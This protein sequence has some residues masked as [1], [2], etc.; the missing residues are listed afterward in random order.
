MMSAWSYSSI[1]K[2]ETCP[3][4]YQ[5]IKVLK[6]VKEPPTEV[7]IWGNAVHLALEE[8]VRDGKPLPDTMAKWNSIA[9]KIAGTKGTIYCEAQFAFNRNLDAVD[10]W[11]P[12]GW[13]RGV[14]DVWIDGGDKAI[15]YDYKT[16]K[17]K[18]DPDQLKLFAAFI[19]QSNPRIKVVSTGFI[20]LAHN[21]V[22]V[23][24]YTRDDLEDIWGTFIVRS[25]RLQSSFDRD[26]WVPKPSGLC[27]GWC[28]VGR[29]NCEFWAPK[30]KK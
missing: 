19:M 26:K 17:V 23:S 28:A 27:N 8:C 10:W 25:A 16:G 6:K 2:Y 14:I 4:Q 9:K 12:D 7:T 21:K 20:W 11:A 5:V 29:A 1:T 18:D 22:S 24:V 3:R 30:R 15:A 13:C